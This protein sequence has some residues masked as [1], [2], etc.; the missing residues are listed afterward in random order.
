MKLLM[1]RRQPHANGAATPTTLR[2]GHEPGRSLTASSHIGARWSAFMADAS[3]LL[4]AA[5]LDYEQTLDNLAHA[6]VRAL[7]DWCVAD[8]CEP[9]GQTKRL[10]VAH[11]DPAK[12]ELAWSYVRRCPIDPDAAD[13]VA[14][15]IRDGRSLLLSEIPDDLLER[16]ARDAEHLSIMRELGLHS[17]MIVPLRA[18][19]RTLGALTFVSAESQVRY[20]RRDLVRA[21]ELASRA[22]L[23]VDN[24]RL[25][26]ELEESAALLDTLFT[27]APTGLAFWD[28][29]LRY[30]RVNDALAA[31]NGL[32]P[33]AHLGC[34]VEE[35]LPDI[36]AQVTEMLRRVLA[37]GEP[38]TDVEVIGETP[39][40]PGE[41]RHWLG[42]Y[43][44][45][46]GRDGEAIGVGAVLVETTCQA[47]AE[48]E[49]RQSE[50]RFRLLVDGVSDYA[51]FMLDPDGRVT[52]WNEGA[53]RIKRYR[54]EEILGEHFSRFYPPEDRER[55]KPAEALSVAAAEGNYRDSGFPTVRR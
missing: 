35:L 24:A 32:S 48:E 11:V 26:R 30:V 28:R 34:R 9:D 52:S 40:E 2:A 53:E 3:T 20:G 27:E 21:E 39:A 10:A 55:G 15:V 46:N 49:L 37:S 14:A 12:E 43:Y 6:A 44:S 17:A 47:R 38:I 8:M 29:E 16:V 19:G 51:I 45:V 33:E 54:G 36:G 1:A 4:S 41:E 42:S 50:E 18:R 25:H 13:G 22:A 23:A 31:M 5:S 7:A